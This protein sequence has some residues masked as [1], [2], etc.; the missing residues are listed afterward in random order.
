MDDYE[1]LLLRE[2]EDYFGND[3]KRINHAKAVLDFARKLMVSEEADEKVVIPAAILHDIGI[4]E[5]ERKYNSVS[6]HLQEKEGPPIAEEMLIK[7]NYP[8]KYICEILAIIGSHHSPDNITTLN[9]QIVY[10]ADW[11]VNLGED[12]KDVYKTGKQK[13]IDKNFKTELGTN[14]AKKLYLK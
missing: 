6:G 4:K 10:E 7:I 11:L 14:L 12:F 8:R 2:M 5:C 3:F 1:L 9:F 13:I